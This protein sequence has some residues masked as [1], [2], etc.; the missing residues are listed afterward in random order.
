MLL[1]IMLP[2][3]N[4]LH[5][6]FYAKAISSVNNVFFHVSY[7]NTYRQIRVVKHN[8]RHKIYLF[9]FTISCTIE[10]VYDYNY[11]SKRNLKPR[12]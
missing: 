7:L 10:I 6:I 3:F 4:Y 9:N 5:F 12:I 2:H 8:K 11:I 1:F